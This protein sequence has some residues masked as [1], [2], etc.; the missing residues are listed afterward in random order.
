LL[1]KEA[2]NPR[3]R[4]YTGVTAPLLGTRTERNKGGRRK[5]KREHRKTWNIE[6]V[7][8]QEGSDEGGGIGT[9]V[10]DLQDRRKGEETEHS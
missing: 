9:R 2:Q 1:G 3:Q 4:F 6:L 10:E 7:T 5:G 8:P